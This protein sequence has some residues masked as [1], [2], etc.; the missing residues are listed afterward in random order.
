MG[1]KNTII[2]MTAKN[3]GY[4]QVIKRS[5]NTKTG[6]AKWLCRCVCGK[7]KIIRGADLRLGKST[8]CG[9]KRTVWNKT[10]G[11]TG[12]RINRIYFAM[13]SRCYNKN[14]PK[15][16]SYGGRGITVCD[17]WRNDFMAFY[18]WAIN[19]GYKEDLSIDRINNNGN[20]EPKNCRWANTYQQSNNT[21]RNHIVEYKG[22][23]KTISEWYRFF[24]ISH[25]KGEWYFRKG[26]DVFFKKFD[27]IKPISAGK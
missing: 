8:S 13:K 7:E 26:K 24:G 12:T 21:R 18:N 20:Y 11:M 6:S 4:W 17:E 19:N 1:K 23:K 27:L 10:H 16:P 5:E 3:F 22:H 15:Y 25:S 14:N 9:C 2:D